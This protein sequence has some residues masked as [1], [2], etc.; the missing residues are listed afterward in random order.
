MAPVGGIRAPPPRPP[1]P[2]RCCAATLATVRPTTMIA[3]S[4]LL[5]F[6]SSLSVR[7]KPDT[8][9]VGPA[10]AGH[11]GCRTLRDNR[12]L[13]TGSQRYSASTVPKS[14]SPVRAA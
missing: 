1:P 7:L 8:T 3:V 10:E 14:G 11:Y 12:L 2:P 4:T 13:E 6:I 9:T 5:R